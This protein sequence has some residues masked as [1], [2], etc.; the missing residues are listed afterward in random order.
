MS[1][2]KR[3]PVVKDPLS[4]TARRSNRRSLTTER[5]LKETKD[6][7]KPTIIPPTKKTSK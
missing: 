6:A 7:T 5:L 3:R 2:F 4:L 1:W